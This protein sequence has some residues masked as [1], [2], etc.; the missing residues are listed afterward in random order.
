MAK[1]DH[2]APTMSPIWVFSNFDY[3]EET[4]V[5]SRK[6]DGYTG[7][8]SGDHGTK[9]VVFK[10][11][12]SRVLAH[13]IAWVFLGR[14]ELPPGVTVDHADRNGSNNRQGNIRAATK[15][16]QCAN[17]P[18]FKS[19]MHTAPKGVFYDSNVNRWRARIQAAGKKW[20]LG[21]YDCPAAA[22]CAYQIAAEQAF[23]AFATGG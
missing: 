19:K 4:G 6:S 3:D 5:V 9:Y 16:Q 15:S 23:G 17:R 8:M 20:P 14:P 13:N 12:N 21:S 10:V 2:S 7:F 1:Y 18:V 22:S 11:R